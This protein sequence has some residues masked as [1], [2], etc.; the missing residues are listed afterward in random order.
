MHGYLIFLPLHP[1]CFDL[2]NYM[3][4]NY[5][6]HGNRWRCVACESFVSLKSLE[7]CGLTADLLQE[8]TPSVIEDGRDRVEFRSGGSYELLPKRKKR[9]KGKESDP[10]S[11]KPSA[12][13]EVIDLD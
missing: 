4:L 11:G 5:R 8:F 12:Q 13:V 6:V 10:S 3:D 2:R 9:Y 1:Q 7:R